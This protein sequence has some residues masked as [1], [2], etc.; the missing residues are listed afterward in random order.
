MSV[1]V[2]NPGIVDRLRQTRRKVV[3]SFGRRL[4]RRMASFLASQSLVGNPAVFDPKLFPQ[5]AT[6]EKDWKIIR[7]ELDQV[8][9]ARDAIPPFQ[10]VSPDQARIAKG[11]AWKTFIF[12]GFG[13]QAERNCARC[14]KTVELLDKIPNL[15][16]AWFSIMSPGYHVPPHQGVTKGLIRVHLGLKVPTEREKCF[17][18]VG[19]E[20]VVWEEGT[21]HVFDDT[22]EHE[23]YNNTDEERTV[24]LLDFERPMK[25]PARIFNRMFLS[26]IR[27]TAYVQDALKNTR[28]WEDRFEAAVRPRRC[29]D[30]RSKALITGPHPNP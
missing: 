8:L 15:K 17:M 24:L 30:R 28:T 11:D 22:Y 12:Y 25:W 19:D 6:L 13:F 18:R 23:V 3:N 20:K 7:E 26:A 21:C 9:K 10:E 29:H 2:A 27:W 14:P 4:S 16:T 1:N 5:V